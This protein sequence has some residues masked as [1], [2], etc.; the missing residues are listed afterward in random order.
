M[1]TFQFIAKNGAGQEQRGTIEAG[2]RAGA[3]A[4]W[5]AGLRSVAPTSCACAS[6]LN[7]FLSQ[8]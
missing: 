5:R 6:G 1:A 8:A 2:D 3:A 7:R 4:A